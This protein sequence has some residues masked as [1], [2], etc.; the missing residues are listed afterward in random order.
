MD[1]VVAVSASKDVEIVSKAGEEETKTRPKKKVLDEETY[2]ENVERIIVRDFFPDH[3][4]LKDQQ[5]YLA[6]EEKKDFERMRQIALKYAAGGPRGD[7]PATFIRN[8]P[9]PSPASFETPLT[10][11]PHPSMSR[12][13]K[14]FEDDVDNNLGYKKKAYEPESEEDVKKNDKKVSLDKFLS[15]YTSEDNESFE[16]IMVKTDEARREKHAWLYEAE[17]THAETTK[18]ILQLEDSS[19]PLA[20]TDGCDS[21]EIKDTRALNKECATVPIHT[22]EYKTKNPLMYYPEG[23]E[24]EDDGVFKKPRLINHEN[25]RFHDDPFKNTLHQA[26]LAQSAKEQNNLMGERVGHDGKSVIPQESPRVGGYGFVATPSPMPGVNDSPLMTWGEIGSTPARLEGGVTPG[27]AFRFPEDSERDKLTYQMVDANTKKN[28]AKKQAALKQMKASF[29]G[30]PNRMGSVM[31]SERLNTLSP[32]ARRLVS[33]K[34]NLGTDKALKASYTPTPPQRRLA[35]D[36]TPLAKTPTP[37]LRTTPKN[38]PSQGDI[39]DN[40]LNIPSKKRKL[41]ADFF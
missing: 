35:G 3:E 36:D 26:K 10:N 22:W 16:T 11:A 13:E 21:S 15:K 6:A 40:L 1:K 18:E 37:R 19:K 39:T 30:T 5:E 25:T 4:Q 33:K 31:R 34:F 9:L 12:K 38:T 28:R 41:A 32:A 8:T 17:K 14:K 27:P 23:I 2:T 20:I 24:N 7:T 29:L